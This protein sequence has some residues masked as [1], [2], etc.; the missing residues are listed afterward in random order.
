[1]SIPSSKRNVGLT[2]NLTER[3]LNAINRF[4]HIEA[5]SGGIL[6]LAAVIALFWAN[7]E[8]ISE[9]YSHFWHTQINFSFGEYSFSQS[10]HFY[11]LLRLICSCCIDCRT[12]NS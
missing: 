9:S 2:Q 7:T 6:L 8:A 3:S 5:V 10:L 12:K 4:L 1:M 11:L